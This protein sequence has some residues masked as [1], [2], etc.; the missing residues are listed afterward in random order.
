MTINKPFSPQWKETNTCGNSEMFLALM[1]VFVRGANFTTVWDFKVAK[2]VCI[3]EF[4]IQGSRVEKNTLAQRVKVRRIMLTNE[5]WNFLFW[6]DYCRRALLTGWS[7]LI[8]FS[9]VLYFMFWQLNDYLSFFFHPSW[10]ILNVSLYFHHCKTHEV[11]RFV[12][13]FI[14]L[15]SADDNKPP[16]FL[17]LPFVKKNN[18]KTSDYLNMLNTLIRCIFDINAVYIP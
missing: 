15:F 13:I 2:S 5:W 7:D 9:F 3:N 12:S 11:V 17:K 1:H 6:R 10:I 4:P 16:V 18:K 8:W 14:G